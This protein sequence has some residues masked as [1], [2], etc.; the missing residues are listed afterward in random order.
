MRISMG[1]LTRGSLG[2]LLAASE[3]H[4][5]SLPPL[6]DLTQIAVGGLHTCALDQQGRVSCWGSNIA[7][8]LGLG[9]NASD[10]ARLTPVPL[11]DLLGVRTL[12][13]G[14]FHSCAITAERGVVCWGL[15]DNGQLGDG[16]DVYAR[17]TPVATLGL[18]GAVTALATG[19]RHSCALLDG[20]QVSCWGGNTFGQL[21]DGSSATQRPRA[22]S[23]EGLPAA[24][25]LI[26]AGDEHTCAL[27]VDFSVY[28]WGYN[29]FGQLGNNSM[30]NASRPV[31]VQGLPDPVLS[32]AGGANSTC[33]VTRA[34][35]VYCWGPQFPLTA[36]SGGSLVA[37]EY[38]GFASGFIAID[39][40][41]SHF[42]AINT[43][44]VV[45]CLGDNVAGQLGT[46]PIDG[47][48]GA[49]TVIGLT[50]D[51]VQI[52]AGGGH[53]CARSQ[54]G[55]AQCWGS[56]TTGQLGI[57]NVSLR[58]V[59]T[60]V[61]GQA[62]S[63]GSVAV[64]SQSSCALSTTGSVSCWGY[65][66]N[67]ELGDG[68]FRIRLT[69]VTVVGLTAGV[70]RLQSG[71]ASSC[72]VTA[73][74]RL[75]CWGAN[76]DGRLGNG[77]TT[78]SNVPV[79]VLGLGD[80][81]VL[82]VSIGRSHACALLAGGGVKCWGTNAFGQIG[83]GSTEAR[84]T[85]VDVVGLG[86]GVRS[87]SA[88]FFHTCAVT[89]TGAMRC[90]GINSSGQL[91][92][93]STV[94]RLT[95]ITVSGL[96][97]GVSAASAGALH[98][99]ALKVGGAVACWG[100]SA[101]GNLLGDGS[102]QDRAVPGDVPSLQG[103][104]V[105]LAAGNINTCVRLD[106]TAVQCWGQGVGDNTNIARPLPTVVAGLTRGASNIDSGLGG[107][108]CVVLAGAA[109]CWG[110]NLFGQI[111][112]DSSHGVPT[113]QVVL[114]D[115]LLRR[116][117]TV[118]E[119][120]NAASTDAQFDAS[121]RFVVFQSAADNLVAGD[122]NGVIDIFRRDR[123]TGEVL[124]ISVDNAGAQLVSDA[125][126]ASMT[127]DAQLVVF[128][129]A[130]NAAANVLGESKAQRE[131]RLKGGG[132]GLFLRNL[133]T[134]TTQRLG[135]AAAAGSQ[136]SI[137]P[138]GG[139]VV[140]SMPTSDPA[141]GVLG[142]LNVY[143]IPLARTGNAVL[144]SAARCLTCKTIAV[145]GVPTAA[146]S[147]GES[148]NAVVSANG[149]WVAY[150]TAASNA[151]DGNPAPCAAGN[152]QVML[153]DMLTG[154]TQRV[155]PPASLLASQCGLT[156]SQNPSID[157]SGQT[158]AWQ[159]DQGI[160][161]GDNNSLTDI[162]LWSATQPSPVRLS[163][164]GNGADTTGAA[165]SP[166]LSGDG[167]QLV[168][169]SAA[170]NHDLEFAD[171]NERVDVHSINL[172]QPTIIQRLSRNA[173]GSEL[174]ANS[175]A[176]ALNFDGTQ[177]AFESSAS[178]LLAGALTGSAIVARS[179]PQATLKRSA[180]W[181]IPAESGWGL[182][183]F[184]QGNLLAPA[185]FT[186]DNDGEPTWFLIAGA[187]PQADGSFVGPLLR[188]TG[189]PFDQISGPAA[190]TTTPIG[191]VRLSFAGENRLRFAYSA[192]GVNQ[193]KVLQKFPFGGR[194]FSCTTSPGSSRRDARNFTD[195]WSGAGSNAGWGLTLLHVDDLIAGAWFTYDSDGEAV[196]FVISTTRQADGSF[197]GSI[198]RQRNGTPFSLIDNAAPS[199]G[200]DVIGS[201]RF[202]FAD[203][204]T[205]SFAYTVNGV[206]QTRAINRL[207]VGNQA[208]VCQTEDVVE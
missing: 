35:A 106:T 30:S 78:T 168:F 45:K 34:G 29:A 17:G 161:M 138:D 137:A 103:G 154:A 128:V 80:V 21:G 152:N 74:R 76:F 16:S 22:G 198:F 95:P 173:N 191:D 111:G 156:G 182:T 58:L 143:A 170:S 147:N 184:D 56:N 139:L 169:V 140:V 55:G 104:V 123:Q 40:G 10:S 148:Q 113:A 125:T 24:A 200:N 71:S 52:S 189:T 120:A 3:L 116:L 64:G 126:A 43:S 89:E 146:N 178:N 66:L 62:S 110:D 41:N 163:Q 86:S 119:N 159:S 90:W 206:S 93:G 127:A 117:S 26:A 84:L 94:N 4:A 196:F 176:P 15:N 183:V 179:N 32:L 107:H 192:D 145:A 13:T 67:G 132:A 46:G 20:G 75:K 180:T 97:T 131:S 151:L 177:L 28:C 130:N 96:S 109:Q 162:Y 149:Q 47:S 50:S 8:Q 102:L 157:Y 6:A 190:R 42:C 99:C 23:V 165:Q 98:T 129:A 69:P 174:N 27:L 65:N 105:E 70:R 33:A 14:Y 194:N 133:L 167:N 48:S 187:F 79:D 60:R 172:Q 9:D 85:A 38:P 49:E 44:G 155:S 193:T 195:L 59:P 203:G 92:D 121:G 202:V 82:D 37:R 54:S 160:S 207:Q 87:I 81:D 68:T 134:G 205:A 88:G 51:T 144:P 201:A 91:G 101:S 175:E 77:S 115:E 83:D 164:G 2:L 158:V 188:F 141:L 208:Q 150:Q 19:N 112:D 53:S 57:D 36:F 72:A 61:L 197:S 25:L 153:R 135:D 100:A 73:A 124:R 18:S 31:R 199:P 39:G 108:N 1:W 114:N 204:E 11:P 186:Y 5:A 7:G 12:S 185:W 142:Q 136:P 118:T 171:N 122:S 63:V 166:Q 181:W